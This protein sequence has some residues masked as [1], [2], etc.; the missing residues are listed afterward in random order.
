MD[1]IDIACVGLSCYDLYFEVDHHPSHDEKVFS[2]SFL[3]AGGG[4]AANAAVAIS[5]L[6][7]KAAFVGQLSN[8]PFGRLQIEEFIAEGVDTRF[9]DKT[10]RS[11]S[12]SSVIVK[13]DGSRSVISQK[14][15][16]QGNERSFSLEALDPSV[17]LFDGHQLDIS[18]ALL[19]RQCPKILDA[20]SVH[21][22]TLA[23]MTEVDH[24]VC[25][26]KFARE[27]SGSDDPGRSLDLLA[28]LSPS[29]IITLGANGLI[30]R[31]GA[32]RGR[33]SAFEVACVDSTGAGDAFH[34]AFAAGV[35]AGLAWE[36]LLYF[37]SA[38]G[39]LC[40][41][42]MG[43]RKGLPRREEVVAFLQRLGCLHGLPAWGFSSN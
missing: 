27:W 36:D 5:R 19:D 33:L 2:R 23:L 31:K 16:R 40:C 4:P 11:P 30:W 14:A 29:V 6:G 32:E 21:Q 28:E 25:S 10:G 37:A 1:G 38:V 26:E 3:A 43:A 8:D 12:I 42:Q 34:G 41:T 35:F 13:P 17:L 15:E 18:Q 22:G 39:A 20:G 9:V 24:L 7:Y